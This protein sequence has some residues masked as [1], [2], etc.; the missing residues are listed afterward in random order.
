MSITAP[1]LKLALRQY[2]SIPHPVQKRD[3]ALGV[4]VNGLKLAAIL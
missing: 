3:G 4:D 1:G 2:I